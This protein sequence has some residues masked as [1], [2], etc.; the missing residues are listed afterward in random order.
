VPPDTS[1]L[2]LPPEPPQ[3][4]I[5][6]GMDAILEEALDALPARPTPAQVRRRVTGRMP[7]PPT[8]GVTGRQD[9]PPAAEVAV[10]DG[11]VG[12]AVWQPSG[13]SCLL[14]ARLDGDVLVWRPSSVQ[15]EP[16]ELSCGPPTALARLRTRPPH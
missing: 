8:H 16:D 13:W 6:D 7:A 12:V 1:A 2:D 14:G 4:S 9:L 15:M 10:V 5:P 11:D 3:I